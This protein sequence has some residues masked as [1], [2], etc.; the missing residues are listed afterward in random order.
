M[1]VIDFVENIEFSDNVIPKT[2]IK[3]EEGFKEDN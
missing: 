2:E 1:E 3:K